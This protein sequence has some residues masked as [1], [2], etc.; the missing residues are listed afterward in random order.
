MGTGRR[1]SYPQPVF[2]PKDGACAREVPFN[3]WV[4]SIAVEL[5]RGPAVVESLH[6]DVPRMVGAVRLGRA[7]WCALTPT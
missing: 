3:A 2:T 4:I 7:W 6:T 5:G 1:E